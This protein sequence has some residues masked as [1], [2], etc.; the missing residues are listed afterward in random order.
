MPAAWHKN[1]D[2]GEMGVGEKGQEWVIEWDWKSKHRTRLKFL[3]K[4]D[5]WP[6]EE[7]KQWK[8]PVIS[9]FTELY[10][11]LLPSTT[12]KRLIIYMRQ[13]RPNKHDIF[14][15][16]KWAWPCIIPVEHTKAA[17][18]I[19]GSMGCWLRPPVSTVTPFNSHNT[20]LLQQTYLNVATLA[21]LLN[22]TKHFD[23]LD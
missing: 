3:G 10:F 8:I 18:V 12:G 4:K 22:I 15:T 23:C 17:G 9:Y 20:S 19:V 13:Q 5:M 1:R 7:G 6:L 16:L 11:V 21:Q 14:P 2:V